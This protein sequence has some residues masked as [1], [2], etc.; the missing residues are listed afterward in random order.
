[1]QTCIHYSQQRQLND[2]SNYFAAVPILE[3]SPEIKNVHLTYSC[4]PASLVVHLEFVSMGR[5]KR[6][7]LLVFRRKKN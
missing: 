6:Y 5:P 7:K 4:P 3:E 1:M 2:L